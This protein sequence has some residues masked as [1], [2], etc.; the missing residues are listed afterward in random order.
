MSCPNARRVLFDGVSSWKTCPACGTNSNCGTADRYY[1]DKWAV[2]RVHRKPPLYGSGLFDAFDETFAVLVLAHVSM[3]AYFLGTA[4][5]TD[6]MGSIGLNP[7][8]PHCWPMFVVF[9][10]AALVMVWK[11]GTACWSTEPDVE[12]ADD[13]PTFSDA[14]QRGLIVNEDDDY[15]MAELEVLQVR[16]HR[17]L[18]NRLI[19]E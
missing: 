9:L 7:F 18:W 17:S 3:F 2:L 4:G 13:V 10:L 6:P 11:L 8:R 16:A 5:G 15:V 1:L 19:A 14:Y 12:D